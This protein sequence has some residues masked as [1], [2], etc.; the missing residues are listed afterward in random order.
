MTQRSRIYRR[1]YEDFYGIKIPK[2][3]HIHHIDGNR[4][5]NDPLNLQMVTPEEHAQIHLE[6][7]D[8]WFNG[9]KWIQGPKKSNIG[10]KHSEETKRKMSEA[11]KGRRHTENTKKL[12]ALKK[13]E[14]YK[15]HVGPRFGMKN[16]EESKKKTSQSLKGHTHREE[17]KQKMS[18]SR[19]GKSPTEYTKK[20]MSES[21]KNREHHLR[22]QKMSEE[23][24]KKISESLKKYFEGR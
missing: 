16:T 8:P 10:R 5:N 23:Q 14:Y 15:S 13:Q 19:K 17:S 21:H 18:N 1:I 9:K 2:G 11:Q 7:G 20:K 6:R 4:D 3:M 12:I 24:K 22:G